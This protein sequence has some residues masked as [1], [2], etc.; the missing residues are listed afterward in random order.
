MA[1]EEAAGA[2]DDGAAPAGSC[3]RYGLLLARITEDASA[4]AGSVFVFDRSGSG[5]LTLAG[6][7]VQALGTSPGYAYEYAPTRDRV[8][9]GS[10]VLAAGP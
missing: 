9:G 8:A 7:S 2:G 5:R 4:T 6:F 10:M 1:L 3:R